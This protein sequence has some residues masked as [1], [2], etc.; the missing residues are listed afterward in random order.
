MKLKKIG[1]VAATTVAAGLL[2]FGGST[3]ASAA[4][5]TPAPSSSSSAAPGPGGGERGH[6]PKGTEVTG[7]EATKVGAAVTSADSAVT[8]E[9]VFK[10]TDGTYRVLGTKD[11]KRV[12]FHVSADLATV[13]E[14]KG[15]GERGPKGTEVTGDE[16]TKVGAA[17][18]AK[19]SAV[20]VE[21]V[22][23]ATDG[24]YRV[25][26]TKDGKR[27]GFE[28]SADLATV[29]QRAARPGGGGKDGGRGGHGGERPSTAPGDSAGD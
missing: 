6:G 20:T 28:V 12:G 27:V 16:A 15:R 3:L 8:V 29:T 14:G 4:T 2:V 7:D 9:R 5:P 24:T 11:G 18:T 22:F 17:V 1:L 10:A 23:K 26:G 13:S 21:R 25:L 19:D